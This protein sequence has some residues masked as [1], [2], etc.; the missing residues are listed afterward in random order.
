MWNTKFVIIPETAAATGTVTHVVRK[1]LEPIPWE[2]SIHSAQKM[3]VLGT[4]YIIGEYC[5]MK[6]EA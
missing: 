1:H 2:H 6:L 5:N 4:S 3:A